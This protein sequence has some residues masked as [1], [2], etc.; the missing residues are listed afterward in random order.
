MMFMV[1]DF[2]VELSGISQAGSNAIDRQ[3]DDIPQRPGS[4]TLR[5]LE[6]SQAA[7]Q[8]E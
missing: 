6:G 7:K 2:G 4:L 3:N 8:F 5:I 1:L